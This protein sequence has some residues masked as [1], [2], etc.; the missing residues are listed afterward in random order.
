MTVEDK[1]IVLGTG[2]ANDAA[3]DGSGITATSSDGNKTWN[4]VDSTDHGHHLS[5][6]I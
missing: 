4:W 5:T 2:A 1:N 3:C 6:L